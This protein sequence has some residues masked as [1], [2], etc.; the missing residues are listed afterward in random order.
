MALSADKIAT[1]AP[2]E[3]PFKL[4]DAHGL[5]LLVNPLMAANIGD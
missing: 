4:F 2:A 3:K 1:V 5:Y